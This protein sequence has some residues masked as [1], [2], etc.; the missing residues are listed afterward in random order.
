MQVWQILPTV[1]RPR[2]FLMCRKQI[3]LQTT[4]STKETEVPWSSLKR[5]CHLTGT[6]KQK[7]EA[8]W[9]AV[10]SIQQSL[11]FPAV[12]QGCLWPHKLR[13][14][15][16][17]CWVIQH[18]LGTSSQSSSSQCSVPGLPQHSCLGSREPELLEFESHTGASHWGKRSF[19]HETTAG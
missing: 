2:V 6:C 9:E 13:H 11:S 17:P 8:P 15:R 1:T 12:L 3:K 19:P 18:H 5:T 7:A 16:A 4:F 14:A 10:N